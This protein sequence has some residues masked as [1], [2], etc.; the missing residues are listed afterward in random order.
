[1]DTKPTW[2]QMM[3]VKLSMGKPFA[4]VHDMTHLDPSKRT[5]IRFK[6]KFIEL[7]E[8]DEG[9]LVHYSWSKD[10][11]RFPDANINDFWTAQAKS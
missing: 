8:D 10:P 5:I 9:D 2:W 1:M 7:W 3:K 11:H 6:D 4:P